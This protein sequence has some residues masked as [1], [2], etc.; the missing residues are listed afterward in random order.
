M[1][2]TVAR[3]IAIELNLKPP[4]TWTRAPVPELAMVVWRVPARYIAFFCVVAGSTVAL[5]RT[6]DRNAV[7]EAKRPSRGHLKKGNGMVRRLVAS[8]N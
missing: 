3:S 4:R 8:E 7:P 2:V 1:S 5:P 6:L